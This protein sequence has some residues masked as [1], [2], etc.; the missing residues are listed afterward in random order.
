M[1]KTILQFG[2]YAFGSMGSAIISFITM[3]IITYFISPSE[4]GKTSMFMLM[5]TLLI[6]FIYLGF[7]QAFGREF[8]E[9]SDKKR[10]FISAIFFPIIFAVVLIL[11]MILFAGQLS[12][13]LFHSDTYKGAIYFLAISIPFLIFER[14]IFMY[15]RM[16]KKA[17]EFSLFNI[18]IKLF[19][20]IYTFTFLILFAHSFITVVYAAIFGQLLGDILMIV[21][22]HKL[23][24]F[25]NF[26]LDFIVLKRLTQFAIPVVF[27]TL[28]YCLFV[29]MDK[30]FLRQFS[31]FEQ[32]G[33]YTSAFKIASALLIIQNVFANLWV[34]TA[35]KWYIDK[36]PL[37]DFQRVSEIILFLLA[38]LFILLL[39]SKHLLIGF[40][41]ADYAQAAYIFPFL[42]FYPIMMTVSETTNVGI[43]FSRKSH[44]NI[45]VSLIT[46]VVSLLLN[47]LLVPNLGAIGAAIA[48]GTSYVVFFL[49]RS[50]FSRLVW[51]TFSL[52]KHFICI[53]I[54]YLAA[55]VNTFIHQ[56]KLVNEMNLIILLFLVILNRK[57]LGRLFQIC[58]QFLK[59]PIE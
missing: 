27:A 45:Y 53:P 3:P 21:K 28:L 31:T 26:K 2:Q 29:I 20:L 14:F 51:E 22:N 49:V 5:Q 43:G 32:L 58:R 42:C 23:L 38:I 4:Y 24:S 40:L 30:L 9:Y 1:K 48:M 57:W 25:R 36:R 18:L 11:C 56:I 37:A 16:E 50:I 13:L 44:L 6:S 34:P 17:L 33:L 52:K 47:F 55:L 8:Y 39:F 7:D 41:S 10:L 35:T 46:L 15:I 12:E 54:L 19:I 59:K